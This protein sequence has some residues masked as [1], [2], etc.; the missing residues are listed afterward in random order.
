M[1]T[2]GNGSV[3]RF[4]TAFSPPWFCQ[5]CGTRCLAHGHILDSRTTLPLFFLPP[6]LPLFPTQRPPAGVSTVCRMCLN[7]QP[8]GI[9]TV[10]KVLSLGF[11][12]TNVALCCVRRFLW[13]C[14]ERSCTYVSDVRQK[15]Q[16]PLQTFVPSCHSTFLP[17]PPSW[18]RRLVMLG[19]FWHFCHSLCF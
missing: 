7:A 2:V 3:F 11:C 15:R 18:R 19:L 8:W 12:S 16:R 6:P 10:R 14:L 1:I 4:A 5:Y 17:L 13:S 9:S